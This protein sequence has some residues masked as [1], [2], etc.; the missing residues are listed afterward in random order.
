MYL[1]IYDEDEID[2]YINIKN[3]EI[4]DI[5]RFEGK[6]YEDPYYLIMGNEAGNEAKDGYTFSKRI[7]SLQSARWKLEY[8]I[9]EINDKA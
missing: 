9:E 6:S 8:L 4:F 5:V 2:G 7:D 1:P 3:I